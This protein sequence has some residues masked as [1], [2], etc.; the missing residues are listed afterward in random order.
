MDLV[1]QRTSWQY[2]GHQS[3]QGT[4]ILPAQAQFHPN[5]LMDWRRM[6]YQD[7]AIRNHL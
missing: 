3:V 1:N 6:R 4:Q 7:T 5:Y 2:Q